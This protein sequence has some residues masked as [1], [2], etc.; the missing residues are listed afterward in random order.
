ME[1]WRQSGM[2]LNNSC[3]RL[4]GSMPC[5]ER[6]LKGEHGLYIQTVIVSWIYIHVKSC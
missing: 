3:I 4:M 6:G 1:Q 2:A 5:A